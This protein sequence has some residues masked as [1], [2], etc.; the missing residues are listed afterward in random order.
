MNKVL[1]TGGT[2]TLGRAIVNL[3]IRK[4]FH[5]SVLSSSNAPDL[6][7]SVKIFKGNLTIKDSLKE[8][9][10][11]SDIIIHCATNPLNPN[12]IDIEGTK[13]LLSH[14]NKFQPKHLVYISIV[15]IDKS[16]YPYYQAKREVENMI[17]DSN[18]SWSILRTTQ[19]HDLVLNYFLLPF[20][21]GGGTPIKVPKNLR[22]Q[23][24]DI[25][26]VA[27]TLIEIA[28]GTPLNSTLTIGGPEIL[29]IE[30]MGRIYLKVLKRNDEIQSELIE[31][32][33]YEIF[34]SGINLYPS[35]VSGIIS[36]EDYL[37]IKFEEKTTANN[38]YQ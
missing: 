38:G 10:S 1:V 11:G 2:G 32:E 36:W 12:A 25:M 13:N 4:G 24:I 37:R 34:R 35:Q 19:F 26:D 23:S 14:V 17:K 29:S 33:L 21:K 22:F 18:F 5:T 28:T 16:S 27:K 31:N 15:G 7:Y 30:E 8:A 6:P 3:L 9:V 20:D